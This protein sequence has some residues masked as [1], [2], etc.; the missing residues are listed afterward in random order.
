MKIDFFFL[1]IMN[2]NYMIRVARILAS[3]DLVGVLNLNLGIF[4]EKEI[5][6]L[7]SDPTVKFWGV[8]AT[9]PSINFTFPGYHWW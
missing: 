5:K 7:I 9:M 4:Q 6:D 8:K 3:E 2:L 1:V